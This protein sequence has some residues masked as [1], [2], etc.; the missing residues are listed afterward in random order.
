[1]CLAAAGC[2]FLPWQRVYWYFVRWEQAKASEKILPVVRA[3]LRL[4]EGRDPEP[5]AGLI[6]SQSVKGADTVGRDTRGY[7]AGNHAGRAVRPGSLLPVG[8]SAAQL[9]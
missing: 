9:G 4:R 3:Q 1:V 6:D 2:G 7:D 5:S 8:V